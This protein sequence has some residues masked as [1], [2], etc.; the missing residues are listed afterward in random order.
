[1]SK[2]MYSLILS[3]DIIDA[4]DR[5]AAHKGS[6]R[7]ALVN[8]ILAEYTSMITPEMRLMDI[9]QTVEQI[10]DGRLRSNISSGGT[11]TLRTALQ[12]KYNPQL[13]YMLELTPDSDSFGE[14]RVCIRSQ[15]EALLEYMQ[16]FFSV[17][18][19]AEQQHLASPPPANYQKVEQ[20][21][22][23]RTLRRPTRKLEPDSAGEAVAGYVNLIDRCIKIFFQNL[24]NPVQAADATEHEYVQGLNK[25]GY[26]IEF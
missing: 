20:K 4:I 13:N 14:L 7:S 5:L 23:L 17:W 12:Y 8:H 19:A 18:N 21:R 15:N 3:D 11:M 26:A 9:L 24:D 22:Y 1:M 10:M 25:L 2:S 6:S 16:L